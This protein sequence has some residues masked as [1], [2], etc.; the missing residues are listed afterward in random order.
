VCEL[1]P[2]FVI[3]SVGVF[4]SVKIEYFEE[5]V[6]RDYIDARID[7]YSLESQ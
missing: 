4:P 5:C 3:P 2:S 7:A 1:V 6:V